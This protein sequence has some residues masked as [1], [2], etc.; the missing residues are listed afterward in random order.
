MP[1]VK[2][3]IVGD[4][5]EAFPPHA[6]TNAGLEHAALRLGINVWSDWIATPTLERS[7]EAI[8][9]SYDGL[10]IAPG[11]PYT[12]MLGG[13]N[14]ITYGRK[15]SVP[16]IATCGGY[17]HVVLEYARRVLGEEDAQHAEYDPY[18][19]KLFVSALACSLVGQ[20]LDVSIRSDS[21]AAAFYNAV[22]SSEQYYCNFGLNPE[23]QQL[24]DQGGLRIVGTDASGEARILEL[25][26]HPFFVATLFVPPL[27][28]TE[29]QP[30][31]LLL[32]FV[33]AAL[34]AQKNEQRA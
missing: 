5:N 9:T 23:Y 25:P 19:S 33:K 21:R 16:L 17:Q 8:L 27:S 7:A 32:A 14:A 18:A 26:D 10:Y 1:A 3:A 28:S 12:S 4:Y 13:L 24:L 20:R 31:P 11:S 34:A 22:T 15:R 30:H 2:V 6:A 29:T